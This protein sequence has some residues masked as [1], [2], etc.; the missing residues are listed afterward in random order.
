LIE[1]DVDVGEGV[2]FD[3][4]PLA[5]REAGFRAISISGAVYRTSVVDGGNGRP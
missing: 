2:N 5:K 1:R 3:I 4:A